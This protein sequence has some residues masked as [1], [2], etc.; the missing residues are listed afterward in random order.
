[1]EQINAECRQSQQPEPEAD[2]RALA[3]QFAFGGVT[4]RAAPS[5]RRWLV[6]SHGQPQV[7]LEALRASV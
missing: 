7:R 5:R 6:S 3:A 1:M 2:D 4:I